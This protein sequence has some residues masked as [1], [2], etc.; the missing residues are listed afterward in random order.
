MAKALEFESMAEE[1]GGSSRDRVLQREV[2]GESQRSHGQSR[3][4]SE[5]PGRGIGAFLVDLQ[6]PNCRWASPRHLPPGPLCRVVADLSE[7]D[8]IGTNPSACERRESCT[9]RVPS[10]GNS[11][12]PGVRFSLAGVLCRGWTFSSPM[13]TKYRV[14]VSLLGGGVSRPDASDHDMAKA[15][16]GQELGQQ[17]SDG[18]R[19]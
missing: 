8:G 11:P 4:V 14:G 16:G 15:A 19:A 3:H 1:W 2:V 13:K 6:E 17:E 7:D 10:L 9:K 18:T 5:M 12:L